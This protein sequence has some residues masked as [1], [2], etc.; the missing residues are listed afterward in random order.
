MFGEAVISAVINGFFSRHQI[1]RWCRLIMS[2]LTT[3]LCT[4]FSVFG[5]TGIA[6][7]AAGMRPGL[8]F[9]YS[10]FEGSLAMAALVLFR[11]TQSPLTKKIPISVPGFLEAK[12]NEILEKESI[13]THGEEQK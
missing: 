5:S 12:K 1:E 8:A 2:C 10:T 4:F 6:H 3:G 13:V 11:W 9:A 7:L